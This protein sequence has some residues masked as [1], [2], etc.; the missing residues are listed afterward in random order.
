MTNVLSII[1]INLIFKRE[2]IVEAI[3]LINWLIIFVI[4]FDSTITL[5]KLL[6]IKALNNF[7]I[8]ENF[9]RYFV[10]YVDFAIQMKKKLLNNNIRCW[11]EN[12]TS[13]FLIQI[14]L[15]Q[16][17]LIENKFHVNDFN[18]SKNI[19][20]VKTKIFVIFSVDENVSLFL[21]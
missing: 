7:E 20:N 8:D 14:I 17:D 12:I 9:C 11:F 6:L 10:S 19:L 5:T 16:R 15:N 4:V 21:H 1:Q 13:K 2:I 18:M 3:R